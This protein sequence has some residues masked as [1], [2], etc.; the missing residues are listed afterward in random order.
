MLAKY[1]EH[2]FGGAFCAKNYKNGRSRIFGFWGY[3]ILPPEV[4]LL[5]Q[6]R[7]AAMTEIQDNNQLLKCVYMDLWASNP[8]GSV[9]SVSLPLLR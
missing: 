9:Q 3:S 4:I 5:R 1:G 6:K 2:R 7:Q 8:R